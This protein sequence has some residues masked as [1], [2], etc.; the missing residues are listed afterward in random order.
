MTQ[1]N[2]FQGHYSPILLL[3]LSILFKLT[4]LF[5][6]FHFSVRETHQ[7]AQAQQEKN[8]RLREAFGISEYFVEGTSF[9]AERKAKE[10][11]AKSEALQKE[12]LEKRAKEDRDSGKK[13]ALVRTPSL[14]RDDGDIDGGL[15]AKKHKL[16]KK[17]KKK[18]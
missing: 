11:L 10:D 8:A 16:S 15:V 1:K 17:K 5:L 4:S 3:L 6:K 7:I 13:Y 18:S 12:L 2:N 9:D 14:D